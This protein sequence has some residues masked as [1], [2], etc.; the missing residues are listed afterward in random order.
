VTLDPIYGAPPDVTA[1]LPSHGVQLVGVVG[2]ATALGY[3]PAGVDLWRRRDP[4]LEAGLL[5][6]VLWIVGLYPLTLL[7]SPLRLLSVLPWPT[8]FEALTRYFA[9]ARAMG[10]VALLAVMGTGIAA[11]LRRVGWSAPPGGRGIWLAAL[12]VSGAYLLSSLF[13]RVP[14][15]APGSLMLPAVVT[16][17]CLLATG[18]VERMAR[19]IHRITLV[20]TVGSLATA[21]VGPGWIRTTLTS[22]PAAAAAWADRSIRFQGLTAHPNVLG[23]IAAFSVVLGFWRR[24]TLARPLWIVLGLAALVLSGS[25]TSL[26]TLAAAG[27]VLLVA[28]RPVSRDR[29][30]LRAGLIGVLAAGAAVPLALLAAV[31]GDGLLAGAT[32]VQGRSQVWAVTLD[33]WRQSPVFGYGPDLWSESFR[34]IHG[35][36]SLVWAAHAHNEY[37]GALGTAGVVGFA[38]LASLCVALV[39][40]SWRAREADQGLSMAVTAALLVVMTTECVLTPGEVMPAFLPLLVVTVATGAN[41]ARRAPLTVTAVPTA[42]VE[43]R[44][45]VFAEERLGA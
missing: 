23:Q 6:A 7:I 27:A 8:D 17:V 28:G 33:A 19:H 41:R 35:V 3:L 43:A 44:R 31:T 14:S 16:T 25:R 18:E 13:G 29:L 10:V 39:R 22:G 36:A 37:F 21:L 32:T 38:A 26:V 20:W 42:A 34:R 12:G 15:F 5:L 4:R 2:A 9:I 30:R 24:D 1:L 40:T 45:P 11:R